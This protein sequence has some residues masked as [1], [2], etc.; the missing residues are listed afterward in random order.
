MRFVQATRFP[1]QH[2]TTLTI[3]AKRPTA[4][5]L[6]LRI[7]YWAREG[8]VKINGTALPAFAS[9]SSSGAREELHQIAEAASR[10]DGRGIFETSA[11]PRRALSDDGDHRTMPWLRVS[12][13]VALRWSDFDFEKLRFLGG[14]SAI[15]ARVDEV[16]TKC[17][18]LYTALSRSGAYS[19]RMAK[20]A[21]FRGDTDRAFGSPRTGKP[22]IRWAV[23]KVP[24]NRLPSFKVTEVIRLRDFLR[25]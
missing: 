20:P 1:E 17:A 12:E 14:S 8:G 19:A 3:T 5:P 25:L 21:L 16:K 2:T 23:S 24:R 7:P 15:K 13:I 22:D 11:V 10:V 9:P 18:R 4:L 6:N